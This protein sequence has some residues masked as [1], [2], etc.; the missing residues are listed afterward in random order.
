MKWLRR[1]RIT[2]ENCRLA[3]EGYA[4]DMPTLFR[5]LT[6]LLFIAG[7]IYGGMYA[8]VLYVEPK[9]GEM[10]VRIP[11]ERLNQQR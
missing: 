1:R 9:K 4:Q 7:I 3:K 10:T 2:E 11:A 6:T 8:L 5:F